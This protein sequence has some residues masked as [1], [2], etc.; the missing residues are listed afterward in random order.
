MGDLN[1]WGDLVVDASGRATKAPEWLAE[2]GYVPPEKTAVNAHAGYAARYYE[3]DP[4]LN[5][6]AMYVQP[7]PESGARGAVLL[8]QEGNRW[9]VALI[10]IAG[11]YPPNDEAAF[12]DFARSL[13]TPEVYNVLKFAEPLT[14]AVGFRSAENRL[15]HYDQLPRYLENFVAIGDAVFAFNPVYAQGMTVAAVSALNLDRELRVQRDSSD[16]LTGLT[17]RYHN[18]V[19]ATLAMPWQLATG[20]DLRWQGTE[21]EGFIPSPDAAAL[22]A[23]AYMGKVFVAANRNT[24]VLDVFLKV[25]NMVESPLAFFTPEMMQLV[26]AENAQVELLEHEFA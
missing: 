6:K 7:T 9:H 5:W 21:V 12:L 25:Q 3:V 2:L 16:D 23:M 14:E 15:Y 20:E 22:E 11:D 24:T 17:E 18:A 10:G 8:P 26:L 19:A 1:V 13:P 4:S